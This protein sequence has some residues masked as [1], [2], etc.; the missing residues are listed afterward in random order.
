MKRRLLFLLLPFLFACHGDIPDGVLP[1]VQ[2]QSAM[3]DMMRADEMASFYVEHDS[4]INL[5]K[6]RAQYYGEVFRVHKMTEQDFKRSLSFYES[7]PDIF[8]V[9]LDSLQAMGD[10]FQK[11]GDTTRK[12]PPTTYPASSAPIVAPPVIKASDSL[13]IRARRM[14]KTL[15]RRKKLTTM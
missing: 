14:H 3:W 12:L 10:R 5:M 1:P 7:R 11:I 4:S 8:K 15:G 9:V 13:K 2:M 6:R